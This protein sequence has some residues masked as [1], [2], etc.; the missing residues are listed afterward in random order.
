LHDRGNE[1]AAGRRNTLLRAA[2]RLRGLPMGT[3]AHGAP[4]PRGLPLDDDARKL[5]DEV[6]RDAMTR[7]RSA[8][9]LAAGWYGKN[10]GRA[11]RLALDYELLAWAA[12]DDDVPEPECVSADAMARAGDYIEH[13][14]AMLDRVA[15]GLA[16][17]R[18]EAD[19]AAIARYIYARG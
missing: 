2:R 18:S 8:N 13:G 16:I 19:A 5:F 12:R 17:G 1:D 3:D 14:S 4:A 10:P 7:A 9:G 6:R 11:L 15:G